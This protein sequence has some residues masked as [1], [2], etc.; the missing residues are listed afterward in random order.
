MDNN[1]DLEIIEIIKD[2]L[3]EI[4]NKSSGINNREREIIKYRYGLKDNRPVQIRELAK[5]FNTSPKKMKEEVDL[6]EKKIFNI[7]KRYI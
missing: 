6:L 1:I 2:K 5:I 3:E 7:L 4:I